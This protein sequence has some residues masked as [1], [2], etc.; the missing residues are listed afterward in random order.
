MKNFILSA[1][2]LAFAGVSLSEAKTSSFNT[3]FSL[4]DTV[5]KDTVTTP[6]DTTKKEEKK[7]FA[8]AQ[9]T[10]DQDTTTNAP[11]QQQPQEQA[12]PAEA[13]AEVALNDLP[14][15]VKQTLTAD[16]FKEW[17]PSNAYH[18]TGGSVEHY[19]IEVKKGDELRSIKIGTDGKVVN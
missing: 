10:S 16:I 11:A 6:T 7:D 9:Y 13:K 14:D 2:A 15:A 18:V 4:Q 19:V 17:V 8:I 3:S 1:V 5:K 12:A